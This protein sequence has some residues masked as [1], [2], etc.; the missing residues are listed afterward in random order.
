MASI[1]LTHNCSDVSLKL[2]VVMAF[3][4]YVEI[5]MTSIQLTLVFIADP[6]NSFSTILRGE[7]WVRIVGN[8][9]V[10]S[11]NTTSIWAKLGYLWNNFHGA[12]HSI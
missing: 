5:S 7:A 12:L 1:K 3:L 9:W 8:T 6:N 11:T 2:K 10:V 4:K